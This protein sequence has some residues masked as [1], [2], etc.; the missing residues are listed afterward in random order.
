VSWLVEPAVGIGAQDGPWS[1][2]V[3]TRSRVGKQLVTSECELRRVRARQPI[4]PFFKRVGLMHTRPTAD[5]FDLQFSAPPST[6]AGIVSGLHWPEFACT[7]SK[8]LGVANALGCPHRSLDRNY[9]DHW[10]LCFHSV[11]QR[12]RLLGY[13]ECLY[14][15]RQR[16]TPVIERISR[17]HCWMPWSSSRAR[18]AKANAVSY[19]FQGRVLTKAQISAFTQPVLYRIWPLHGQSRPCTRPRPKASASHNGTVSSWGPVRITGTT[20]PPH[21]STRSSSGR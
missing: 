3:E 13:D 19:A 10:C 9:S 6:T 1:R 16:E 7:M 14:H 8:P 17:A 15:A 4:E 11:R 20:G 21:G 2:R 5:C 12:L 18:R